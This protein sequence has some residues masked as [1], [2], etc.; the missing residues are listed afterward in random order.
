MNNTTDILT[1]P[2]EDLTNED[3]VLCDDGYFEYDYPKYDTVK[4][5]C[6]CS[7]I[8]NAEKAVTS[9][10]DPCIDIFHQLIPIK[11]Y[12]SW[13]RDETEPVPVFYVKQRY[14]IGS[15]A[16]QHFVLAMKRAG[17]G[18]KILLSQVVGIIETVSIAYPYSDD[19]GTISK[20]KPFND[21]GEIFEL[22]EIIEKCDYTND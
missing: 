9:K 18:N 17:L 13:Y 22:A 3:L 7:K 4:P 19:M 8:V 16:Y 10:G 2:F 12:Y 21:D 11:N 20:R 15:T 14:K 5:D 1:T 6:Y